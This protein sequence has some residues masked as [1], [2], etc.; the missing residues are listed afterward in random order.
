MTSPPLLSVLISSFMCCFSSFF[1]CSISSVLFSFVFMLSMMMG[2]VAF[3]GVLG[4]VCVFV[5]VLSS[6]RGVDVCG[7][8]SVAVFHRVV[9]SSVVVLLSSLSAFS[10][11]TFLSFLSFLLRFFVGDSSQLLSLLVVKLAILLVA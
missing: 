11:I 4:F 2:L 7:S 3:F 9:S 8:M 6:S 1:V 10:L 5:C